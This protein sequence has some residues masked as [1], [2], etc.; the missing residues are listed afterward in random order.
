VCYICTTCCTTG[1]AEA[2]KLRDNLKARSDEDN[3][4]GEA[5]A[6]H[7]AELQRLRDLSLAD[8]VAE[9][10]ASYNNSIVALAEAA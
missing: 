7:A 1:L 10:L 8:A 9:L 3:H 5:A 2:A 6:A 4:Y